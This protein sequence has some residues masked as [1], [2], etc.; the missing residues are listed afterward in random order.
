MAYYINSALNASYPH[1]I[2]KLAPTCRM[3]I[4]NQT[5]VRILIEAGYF[6]D[7]FINASYVAMKSST[8]LW[9]LIFR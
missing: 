8:A 6:L 3:A 2:A 7:L 4:T 9:E 5:W 1:Q